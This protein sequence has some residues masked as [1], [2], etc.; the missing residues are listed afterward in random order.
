ML[1]VYNISLSKKQ[2]MSTKTSRIVIAPKGTTLLQR[3]GSRSRLANDSAQL[4]SE[5][6]ERPEELIA[7]GGR[8][9]AARNRSFST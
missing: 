8:G 1:R 6:A 5:V 7:Y 3:M 2:I 4:R 9:K